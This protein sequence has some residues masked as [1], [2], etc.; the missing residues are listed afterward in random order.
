MNP[1]AKRVRAP[2]FFVPLGVYMSAD[3]GEWCLR[4]LARGVSVIGPWTVDSVGSWPDES[5]ARRQ[6]EQMAGEGTWTE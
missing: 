4:Q 3:G 6:L 1:P 2:K 5:T